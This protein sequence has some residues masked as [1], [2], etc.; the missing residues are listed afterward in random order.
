V[1]VAAKTFLLI[2][3]SEA[4][5]PGGSKTVRN[6]TFDHDLSGQRREIVGAL[7]SLLS[8]WSS[9][10]VEK[11]LRVRG[12]LLE[13]AVEATRSLVEGRPAL[14]PAWR[15][16]SGVVWSS[17]GP[18]T[19]T[20]PQRRRLLIPS[21]LYGV[22]SGTDLV[23]D[24]RLKMDSSLDPMGSLSQFWRPHVTS[25]LSELTR[26]CVVVDLLPKEHAAAIDWTAL[27]SVC[28]VVRVSFTASSGQGA[29]GHAAKSV[30]GAIARHL[31]DNGLSDL[32]KFRFEGWRVTR[33]GDRFVVVAPR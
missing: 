6:G 24:Y 26:R 31:L 28:R 7:S 8:P 1:V 3:P 32:E 13:R 27:E 9:Q 16:Y 5:A 2:P 17:L 22:N 10:Q 14:L 12:P 4:K 21:G 18:A 33:D 29:A 30:K 19:L 20:T 15:R 25:T 11:V 23:A